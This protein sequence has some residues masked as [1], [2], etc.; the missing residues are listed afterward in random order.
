MV[1]TIYHTFQIKPTNKFSSILIYLPGMAIQ[2]TL[3]PHIPLCL[4]VVHPSVSSSMHM[5]WM[6]HQ[7]LQLSHSS[8]SCDPKACNSFNN[9][10]TINSCLIIETCTP[11]I[12]LMFEVSNTNPTYK[13]NIMQ[14][15]SITVTLG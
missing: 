13:K 9:V 1:S 3:G 8:R 12:T 4:N 11:L 7:S 10:I 15:I 2:P 6:E 5:P 14:K